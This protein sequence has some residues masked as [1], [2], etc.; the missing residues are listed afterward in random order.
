MNDSA[1]QTNRQNQPRPRRRWMRRVV[2]LLILLIGLLLAGLA[3]AP[4]LLSTSGGRAMITRQINQR[5]AGQARIDSLDLNWFA[6]QTIT[7]LSLDDPAGESVMQVKQVTVEA[8]L[9]SLVTGS[10]ALGEVRLDNPTGHI[11]ADESGQTNLQRALASSGNSAGSASENHG[12]SNDDQ[13]LFTLPATAKIIV[14]ETELHM[15]QPNVPTVVFAGSAEVDATAPAGPVKVKVDGQTRQDQLAG[16]VKIDLSVRGFDSQGRLARGDGRVEGTARLSDL[17]VAGLDTLIAGDGLLT[18]ALGATLNVDLDLQ[19]SSTGGLTGRLVMR[20]GQ[21]DGKVNLA[22]DEQRQL[23]ADGSIQFTATPSLA[24]KLTADSGATVSLAN[25]VPLEVRLNRLAMPLGAFDPRAVALTV[26]TRIGDGTVRFSDQAERVSWSNARFT[27]QTDSLSEAVAITGRAQTATADGQGE[28]ALDATVGRLFDRTGRIQPDQAE[29]EVELEARRLPVM[30]ADRLT[31]QAGRLTRAIGTWANITVNTRRTG[32]QAFDVTV[33]AESPQLQRSE[34]ALA[35]DQQIRLS[36]P[37]T[38]QYMM[39][40]ALIESTTDQPGGMNLSASG[41]QVPVNLQLTRLSLPRPG[42]G[43]QIFQPDRTSI[44]ATM[45]VGSFTANRIDQDESL[46]VDTVSLTIDGQSMAAL[47]MEAEARFS[48]AEQ[49]G[50]LAQL[51]G[52]AGTARLT[53]DIALSP[54][55]RLRDA[56]LQLDL[57]AQAMQAEL[58]GKLDQQMQFTLRKPATIR[59]TIDPALAAALTDAPADQP[60]LVEP[61]TL[62]VNLTRL[63]APLQPF[64]LAAVQVEGSGT[65]TKLALSGIEQVQQVSLS[66]GRFEVRADGPG[67]RLKATVTGTTS[68]RRDGRAHQGQLDAQIDLTDWHDADGVDLAGAAGSVNVKLK[69]VP[70]VLV[71]AL[72]GQGGRLVAMVGP[73][74]QLTAGSELGGAD[75]R[76]VALDLQAERLTASGQ[77]GLGRTISMT[78]PLQFRWQLVP[79]AFAALTQARSGEQGVGLTLAEP[80]TISGKVTRLQW[81]MPGEAE[82]QPGRG[83]SIDRAN[84]AFVAE[85][86]ADTLTLH[87][88]KTGGRARLTDLRIGAEMPDGNSPAK[89]SVRGRM[90]YLQS[91][92]AQQ[93]Q[94][95][96]AVDATVTKLLDAWAGHRGATQ[97]D[98]QLDADLAQVPVA[99]VDALVGAEQRLVAMLGPAAD[100]TMRAELRDNQGPIELAVTSELAEA[101]VK[102][103]LGG[104]VV[105][106]EQDLTAEVKVTPELGAKV[107]GDANFLL[108]TAY[109]SDQPITLRIAKENVAIAIQDAQTGAWGLNLADTRIPRIEL[110]LGRIMLENDMVLQMVM[111]FARRQTPKRMEARFTP[112]IASFANGT[113][114]YEKRNDVLIDNAMH[115]VTFGSVDLV[116][117]TFNMALGMPADTLDRLF[118]LEDLPA[119]TV[120]QI[121][122]SGPISKPNID[123]AAAATQMG[124]LQAKMRLSGDNPLLGALAGGALEELLGGGRKRLTVPPPSVS[125][126]PWAGSAQPSDAADS[127]DASSNGQTSPDQPTADQ[128]DAADAP[129]AEPK[130]DDDPGR[131]VL[132]GLLREVLK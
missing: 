109:S 7:G 73:S 13:A 36:R 86:R 55:G 14:T 4:A 78:Q 108:T 63:G 51:T 101:K 56:Q 48:P 85:A 61:V 89:L 66:D 59:L 38:V 6:S 99:W 98:V 94:G 54:A 5:I 58:A 1:E 29:L 122:V 87:E 11:I 116:N 17:P 83:S 126:L 111:R 18:A 131:R 125:P 28:L 24:A 129:Q 32:P 52:R 88:A 74:L 62:S 15:T 119:E 100:L 41:Q 40:L 97:P 35:V 121:P 81:P 3:A 42:A 127:P 77:L 21:L 124:A 20:S 10:R 96:L 110:D 43:E 12:G 120:F 8:T 84:V 82:P 132:E 80:V 60:Q 114:Q 105:R 103:R 117:R 65:L 91:D 95:R 64:D 45:T 25:A 92:G 115:L 112:L 37:T 128:A 31:G 47:K 19:S 71:D 90:R 50:R 2:I 27:V 76:R 22:V 26:N 69:N 70:T 30:L 106:L 57:N 75:Q 102:A 44:A 49:T 123:F 72:A 104:G 130:R 93:G 34:L 9:W 46:N 68:V 53:G 23:T 113:L 107:L 67:N 118:D 16:D 39:P 33:A 79:E